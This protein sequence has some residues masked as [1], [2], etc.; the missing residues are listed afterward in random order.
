MY[1]E[2]VVDGA[3]RGQ[4]TGAVG[5]AAIGVIIYKNR[6]IISQFARGLGRRTN[7]E[8]EYEAVLTALVILRAGGFDDPVIYSDST[9]VVNQVNGTWQCHTPE[10]IPYLL[11]IQD[12]GEEYRFRLE[13]RKRHFVAA[14][15][16]LANEFLDT[17]A[18]RMLGFDPGKRTRVP[19]P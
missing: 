10:L 13:H 16:S 7:N 14:A 6:K 12:L 18:Q 17:L 1:I 4:G 9:V 5:E 15:D 11:T 19:P 2:A 8:A 3:S